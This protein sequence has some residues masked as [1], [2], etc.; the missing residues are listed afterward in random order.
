MVFSYV[1]LSRN[2]KDASTQFNSILSF[3][4]ASKGE[5]ELIFEVDATFPQLKKLVSTVSA[6][7]TVQIYCVSKLGATPAEAFDMLMALTR[8]DVSV[9]S[10]IDGNIPQSLL[11]LCEMVIEGMQLQGRV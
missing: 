11:F 7:D 1:G 3:P 2:S 4:T 5:I 8:K 10:F 6:G 9:V